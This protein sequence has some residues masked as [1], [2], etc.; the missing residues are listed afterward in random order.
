MFTKKHKQELC[1]YTMINMN[2]IVETTQKP[3]SSSIPWVEKYRPTN[4]SDIV[5]DDTNR[6]IFENILNK[7]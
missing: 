5:L 4:F 1:Y 6:Q 2:S 7:N 3:I